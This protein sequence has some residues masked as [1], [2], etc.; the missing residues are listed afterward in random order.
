[1]AAS[2]SH[3]PTSRADRLGCAGRAHPKGAP[4]RAPRRRELAA[5]GGWSETRHDRHNLVDRRKKLAS[6][7]YLVTVAFCLLSAV[8]S[9]SRPSVLRGRTICIDPGHGG[10]AAVDSYRV[11]PTGEREEWIDLR[12][13]LILRQLLEARGSKVLMTR[14]EDVD[15]PLAERARLAVAGKADVFLS[16]HHNATADTGVN[17]PVVYFHGSASEN[18]AS[19]MLGRHLLCALARALHRPETPLSLVSDHTIFPTAG[20]AVLRHS[21][22][23]PGVI[24]EASFF[25]NP[26]EEH[27]LRQPA[28]NRREAEAYVEGLEAFFREPMPAILAK[29]TRVQVDTF[30]VLQEAERM[31]PVARLWR[32]DFLEAERLMEQGDPDA[33]RRAYELFTRSA[34]SFP[35]SYLAGDCHRQRARLLRLLGRAEEAARAQLRAEEYYVAVDCAK[36]P[37]H[38]E[39][40]RSFGKRN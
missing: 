4:P 13:A 3:E 12:V 17:F 1:M 30:R 33:L 37:I 5:A 11:G 21:Y 32:E 39:E 7:G 26:E 14:T 31:S 16:I 22:G 15:V 10:T 36:D 25:T 20:T 35:D 34:R 6:V 29:G 27:R 28:Y 24:V 19:V 18:Q 8:V 2:F 9:C 23:I 40:S 38:G